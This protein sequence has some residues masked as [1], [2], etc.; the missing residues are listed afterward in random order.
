MGPQD[1]PEGL[2]IIFC[3]N[4]GVVKYTSI[5]SSTLSKKHVSV[6]YHAIREAVAAGIILI[7]KEDTEANQSD[8][9]TKTHNYKKRL[10]F[11]VNS[12]LI[13]TS[14]YL[15]IFPLGELHPY[16]YGWN[17]TR[18]CLCSVA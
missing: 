16:L 4:A 1:E 8:L 6:N 2:S 18:R 13:I 7:S 5:P 15:S 3:N 9:F 17:D 12:A 11:P 10:G 14:F